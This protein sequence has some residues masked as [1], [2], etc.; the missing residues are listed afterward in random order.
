MHF[1][2]SA[3][4][5]RAGGLFCCVRLSPFIPVNIFVIIDTHFTLNASSHW[6]ENLAWWPS[7][8]WEFGF[9]GRL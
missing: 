8:S 4:Y 6:G 9:E 1:D 3:N 7:G 5:S 2:C